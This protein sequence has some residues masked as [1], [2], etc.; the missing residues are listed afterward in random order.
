M[1]APAPVRPWRNAVLFAVTCAS[2]FGT[3]LA[4]SDVGSLEDRAWDSLWYA[5]TVMS[6]L[7]AHELGHFL[8]ARHHGVDTSWP[9]FIPLPFGFGT[10]GA[11][12]RL[13][14]RIPTRDALVDIGAAGPLAGLLMCVPLW[15]AGVSLSHVGPAPDPGD[16]FPGDFSL[17]HLFGRWND[18]ASAGP[19]A[20]IFGDNLLGWGLQRLI[21]GRLEPGT[22]LYA[23]PVLVASWLGFL[24]TMLN[25]L[26]VGQLDGGHLTHAWFGRRAETIGRVVAALLLVAALL[27]SASWLAWCLVVTFVVKFGHPPVEDDA[28]PLSTSRKWVCAIC[29]VL[30]ALT[31][32]PTP[33]RLVPLPPGPGQRSATV[34]DPGS[35]RRT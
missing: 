24:V 32:M 19:S 20:Q 33:L 6:I 27:F 21:T 34:A 14:G 28:V 29:F 22:D 1:T 4:Q 10:M 2:T 17:W 8:M 3:W 9:Y 30:T 13:R 5:T 35:M 12:I 26:P 23:H 7:T 18:A 16:G 11:V 31:F 15:I 25:L